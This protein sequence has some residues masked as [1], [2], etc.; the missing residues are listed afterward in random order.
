MRRKGHSFGMG[1]ICRM[2]VMGGRWFVMITKNKYLIFLSDYI[3][4]DDTQVVIELL[5]SVVKYTHV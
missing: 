4:I 2:F 1:P 5:I 3:W